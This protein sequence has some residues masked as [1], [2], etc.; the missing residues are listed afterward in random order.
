MKKV[1]INADDFGYSSAVNLGIIKSH[2]DGILTSTT[3]MANMPGC[4]G[5][6]CRSGT[7]LC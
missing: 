4:Y 1:I 2:K 6:E 5:N 3:L 7:L